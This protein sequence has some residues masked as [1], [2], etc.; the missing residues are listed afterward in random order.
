[1]KR[2]LVVSALAAL[3]AGG[4]PTHAA[5]VTQINFNSNPPDADT[6]TGLLTSSGAPTPAAR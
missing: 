2:A 1:M 6:E 3:A 5:I 4:V